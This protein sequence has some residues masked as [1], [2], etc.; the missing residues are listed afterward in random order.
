[1]RKY[2]P[3]NP[4]GETRQPANA[5]IFAQPSSE[6]YRVGCPSLWM[7]VSKRRLGVY[8]LLLLV[9]LAFLIVSRKYIWL[10]ATRKLAP[11]PASADLLRDPKSSQNPEIL[12]AEANR[13]AW[14]FNWPKAQP[15]YVRAEELFR[16][17]GDTRNDV[18]ARVGRIRAQSETM[19]WTNVSKM[20]GQ[21]LDRPIVKSDQPLRLWCLAAKGYTDLEIN[22]L[23]A[24]QAWEEAQTIAHQL[25]DS[26]WEARAKGELGIIG[27][28][29]GDS[30][31][32]ATMVGDSL[33]TAMASG[34]KGGQ[35]RMLEMLGNGFNEAKR[36]GEALAFFERAIKVSSST[37]DAGF[38]YMAYE[39]ESAALS[40]Q[41]NMS[42][43][44][45]KLQRALA[46]S[47]GNQ[48]LGHETMILLLLGELAIRTGDRQAATKYLEESGQLAQK[49]NFYRTLGQSMI[50]LAG[51]YRDAGDLESAAERAAIGV[52]ASRRVG[53]RYYLP[54]DLT[55]LAALKA[56][57]GDF[58][59][60]EGLYE[61]AEDVIDGI[62][63]DVHE[64]YWSSALAGAMSETYLRHF[65]L[66][67]NQGRVDRALD[68]L[69]RVRGRTASALLQSKVSLSGAESA[70]VR[71]LEDDVS[72]LQLRLMRSESA[73]ER[74]ALLDQLVEH[75]RRLELTRTKEMETSSRWFDRPAPLKKIQEILGPEEVVLEY[76]I[77][78]PHSYCLWI[79]K[80]QAGLQTLVE[81][82]RQIEGLVEKYLSAIRAK[83]DDPITSRRLYDVLFGQQPRQANL[84]RVIVVPDGV[85]NLL[86]F[87]MLRDSN[88]ALVL[89]SRTVSYAPAATVLQVL[90]Q[91]KATAAAQRNFLGVGDVAYQDQGQISA[92]VEK[93]IG[94]TRRL[95]RGMSDAFG[96]TLY[97][98]PQTRE[99]V[100]A[101]SNIVGRD[102]VLLLGSS[103]TETAF[104]AEPLSDFKIVHI[105]AH[106]FADTRFPE[107]S[108]LV[109]GVDPASHDDGL[110]QVREIIRLRFNADLVTLSA[111]NTG[112]GKLEGEEGVT[113]LVEAFLVSGAKSVVASLWSAD[114]TYTLD[115][116]ERFYT[117]IAEGRD[118][119]AA[120]RQAKLD[121][122]AKFGKQLSPYYWGAFVLVG[123]GGSPIPLRIQ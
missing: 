70:D 1:M 113:N 6:T 71:V 23:S 112:I 10:Y 73:N 25:G 63:V 83:R 21:E 38:P 119:A 116:M 78:E 35:V 12:L 120:L 45:D 121:L 91:E 81:D 19:S 102:S 110:L 90:R 106:G 111:C 56:R 47:K 74:T 103:A 3:A 104:K 5:S 51:L 88:D 77:D 79:S 60:A 68:V 24:K 101:A 93:P 50:D 109:L 61:N 15:L 26:Q 59:A 115:L 28:L 55:A 11:A 39:G 18:Y 82:R 117:H 13:L 100:L 43:A 105:A 52:D 98:L 96:T 46:V 42:E 48:K 31:R 108:G 118:K 8:S 89:E 123:D 76:V 80:S 32:A 67:V 87:D 114:D 84:E 57:R 95:E 72:D 7:R 53:D 44:R 33:L 64:A 4:K 58:A 27:F 30:R 36:Y 16:E 86:P 97:D 92:K 99:E 62:L 20:L 29:E 17:K 9:F 94:F 107:R 75:E 14:V 22:P 54:R 85:L 66:E 2:C 34:D 69:E 49:Y 37:P 122:V 65:E 40:S 41:G